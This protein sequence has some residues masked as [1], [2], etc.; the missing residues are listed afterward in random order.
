[1]NMAVQSDNGR[2]CLS[3]ARTVVNHS[4]GIIQCI[5]PG[6]THR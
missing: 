5:E 6:W 1:M 2:H 3:G 4:Q